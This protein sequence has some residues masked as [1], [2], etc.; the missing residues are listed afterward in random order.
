ML[1]KVMSKI[2]RPAVAVPTTIFF[3]VVGFVGAR[4]MYTNSRTKW[5]VEEVLPEVISLIAVGDHLAASSLAKEAE[6]YIPEN[7]LLQELWPRMTTN[8]AIITTP[9]DAEIRYKHYAALDSD[10]MSFGR[11]PLGDSRFPIGAYRFEIQKE[12]YERVE[13]VIA[14]PE[15]SSSPVDTVHV[16]FNEVGTV[17]PGMVAIPPGDLRTAIF[18]LRHLEA[19]K[20][21]AYF[22]DRYEVTNEKY[23]EFVT[24]GGY[25]NPD[26]WKYE[27]KKEGKIIPWAEAMV[28][29][30][31]RTDRLGP[32]TW[33]HGTYAEGLESHPVSG[34]SWYEAEAYARF[35]GKHLPTVFHWSRGYHD[36]RDARVTVRFS[37]YGGNGTAPVGSHPGIGFHGLYDMAG[38]VREWVWNAADESGDRRFI[39]GGA[40]TEGSDTFLYLDVRSP[41]DRSPENGFRTVEYPFGRGTVPETMFRL[42]AVARRDSLTFTPVSN[43]VFESYTDLYSYDRTDLRAVVESVDDSSPLWRREKITFDAAYGDERVTAY[44][45]LPRGVE[46]PYQTVVYFP[47]G[48]ARRPTSSED[49]GRR[50]GMHDY[51][52]EFLVLSGRA[53]IYPVYKGS[54]DRQNVGGNPLPTESDAYRDW[55]VRLSKDVGRAIDFLE[56]RDDI[57]SEKIAYYG[58]SWG[59]LVG[60]M[61]LGVEDR[62]SLGVFLIP[63]FYGGGDIPEIKPINFAPRITVPI[64]ILK[65]TTDNHFWEDPSRRPFFD[66]LGT[67]DADK[68]LRVYPGGHGMYGLFGHEVRKDISDW[69][70]RYFGPVQ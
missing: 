39:L 25:E 60:P 43:E 33:E 31:D 50:Q 13:T 53:V 41:W 14:T 9:P 57:D 30:R 12:G 3:V 59:A 61:I 16:I 46:P 28:A 36:Y 49:I 37:N 66:L 38:N 52:W 44:L 56:T 22:M 40:W 19:V 1:G 18:G 35:A 64:L 10:W 65:G 6:R 27:F 26:F 45:F 32:A 69:L 5:A 55:Q 67:P 15:A 8:F 54:Y 34:V 70:D 29:F 51:F 24:A 4:S 11:S 20:A 62:L 17:P 42:L 68:D 63:S 48:I 47:T 58:V 2:K 7:A 21:P 23:Q